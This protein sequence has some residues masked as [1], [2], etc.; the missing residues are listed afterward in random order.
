[1]SSP[2]LHQRVV[3]ADHPWLGLESFTEATQKYFFGRDAEIADIFVRTSENPLTVLYG[4]SGLGKTSLLGAGLM[5][6]L[7]LEGFRPVLLRLRFEKS[8]PPLVDQVKSILSPAPAPGHITLWEQL[9]H[10]ASRDAQLSTSPPV[11]IFDQFEEVF[12]L[13]QRAERLEEVRALFIELADVIENNNNKGQTHYWKWL[14]CLCN[15][16]SLVGL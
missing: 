9:H 8:D 10:I 4:Q 5:P 16:D 13:G 12:T 2:L 14:A 15:S 11:L 6:K 1:M 7:K 3:D